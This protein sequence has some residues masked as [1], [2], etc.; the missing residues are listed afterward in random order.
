MTGLAERETLADYLQAIRE[1]AIGADEAIAALGRLPDMADGLARFD[2]GRRLASRALLKSIEQ[3]QDLLARAVRVVLILEQ[4]DLT[5]LSPRAIADAAEKLG[6]IPDGDEWAAL[7]RL[8]NELVHEYPLS[9]DQRLARL[10]DAWRATTGLR[11][12]Q[13]SLETYVRNNS[14]LG[15][16]DG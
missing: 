13:A 5:G 2:A 10:R 4:V 1:A 3:M 11:H 9:P 14:I 12:V 6:M 7:V 8:R 16:A 15:D